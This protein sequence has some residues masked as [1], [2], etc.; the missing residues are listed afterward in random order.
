[1]VKSVDDLLID[2]VVKGGDVVGVKELIDKVAE[3]PLIWASYGGHA[4]VV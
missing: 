4:D 2:A 1:M 3:T